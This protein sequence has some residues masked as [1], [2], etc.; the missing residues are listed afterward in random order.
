MEGGRE[1]R[2]TGPRGRDVCECALGTGPQ[3]LRRTSTRKKGLARRG[4]QGVMLLCSARAQDSGA[5]G[6][7]E[8]GDWTKQPKQTTM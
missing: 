2:S 6:V 1:G 3:R 7:G 5:T 4:V 8:E